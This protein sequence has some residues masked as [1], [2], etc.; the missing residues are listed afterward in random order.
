MCAIEITQ[1]WLPVGVRVPARC[2]R[3]RHNCHHAPRLAGYLPLQSVW[4]SSITS[5]PVQGAGRVRVQHTRT[6]CT[7][8]TPHRGQ[9][10][11]RGT[12]LPLCRVVCVVGAYLG[13]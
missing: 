5:G 6:G 8:H 12:G 3:C 11:H 13:C 4:S 10:A 2:C 7:A 1:P 9:G